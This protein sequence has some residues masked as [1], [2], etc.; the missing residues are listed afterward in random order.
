MEKEDL[1]KT[2]DITGLI[3]K[4]KDSKV[5]MVPKWD[6]L[7]KE[8]DPKLHDIVTDTVNRK[9][10]IRKDQ[11]VE[12]VARITYGM[13][14]LATRRM[15][16]MA[17]A[18]PVK[19]IYKTD[20]DKTKIEQA[21]A[22]EKIYQKAKIDAVNNKRLKAYF[23]ACEILTIWFTVPR[24][25]KD[26]GFDSELKLKCVSYSPMNTKYSK[27]PSAN[28]YPVFDKLGDMIALAFQ[29]AVKTNADET[30]YF[31]IYTD[32]EAMVFEQKGAGEWKDVTP[33]KAKI[34]IEKIPGVYM[35]RPMPIWED[36]TNNVNEYELSLSRESDILRKNSA[37]I[38][39]IEGKL[40]TGEKPE[41]ERA[42]EVYNIE[43]GGEIKYVTWE[44]QIDALKFHTE[45]LKKDMEEELQLPNLSFENVKGLSAMSGEAR[46]TLLTDAH[47]KVG[48]ESGDIVEYLERECNV[49]KAFLG[50]MKTEWKTT[51]MDLEVEHVITPFIQNDE[52][53]QV[54]KITKATGGKQIMSQ[55]EGVKQLGVVSDIEAE[56]K[57][58]QDEEET[59]RKTDLF[60]G[61][62]ATG[63]GE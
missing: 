7:K 59:A 28:I 19:R 27:L 24:K 21:A 9:D 11:T 61:A 1:I 31:Y 55:K 54:E 30:T 52:A 40:I 38:L 5:V 50:E 12:K 6:D 34:T 8:F 15:T 46:K 43:N 48:D 26:Y 57:L 58:I 56:M 36:E 49:I 37:P 45:T 20:D 4:I 18:I 29:Y 10:K 41:T 23:A 32:T 39:K 51:I 60:E 44:Q 53:A 62:T 33:D 42:R 2:D 16:Q 35:W 63:E 3:D 14:R 13:Q 47:L 25:N 22:L 17:V